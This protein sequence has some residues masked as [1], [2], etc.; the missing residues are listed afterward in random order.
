MKE[1]RHRSLALVGIVF[2]I[3]V[4]SFLGMS[5]LAPPR[6]RRRSVD[7]RQCCA[8][9]SRLFF[10]WKS[11]HELRVMEGVV[12]TG[13][14]GVMMMLRWLAQVGWALDLKPTWLLIV[15]VIVP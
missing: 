4:D 6:H 15:M 10:H 3:S 9:P 2:I 11:R 5:I 1:E 13:R 8:L 14:G 7:V 12:V